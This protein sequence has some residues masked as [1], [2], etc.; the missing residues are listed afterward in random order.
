MTVM[1]DVIFIAL[2]IVFFAVGT[3]CVAGCRRLE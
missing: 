1:L 2:A 3:A